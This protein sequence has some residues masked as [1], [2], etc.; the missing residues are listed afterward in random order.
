MLE[1]SE[2]EAIG[3]TED[4]GV[5]ACVAEDRVG[6]VVEGEEEVVGFIE[7]GAGEDGG[8]DRG[9]EGAG[10]EGDGCLRVTRA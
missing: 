6:L 9:F 10:A 4:G 3:F 1:E 7:D 8:A 5:T 2:E